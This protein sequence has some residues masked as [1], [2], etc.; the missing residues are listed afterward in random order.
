[1]AASKGAAAGGGGAA[2][3]PGMAFTGKVA[4][5]PGMTMG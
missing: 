3:R 5:P 4:D 2:V 1:M